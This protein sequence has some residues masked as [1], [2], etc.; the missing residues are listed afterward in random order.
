M[1][2]QYKINPMIIVH[3]GAWYWDD[4]VD[5]VKRTGLVH[6]VNAGYT[7]LRNGASALD[8]VESAVRVLEDDPVFDA[9]TG[10]YLNENGTVQLDALIVDGTG[11]DFGAVAGVTKTAHPITLAR[12]V[13]EKTEQC[14]FVGIGA[15]QLAQ[16]FDISIVQNDELHTK[17]MV[18]FHENKRDTHD[19]VGAVAI[20]AQGRMAVATSTSGSPTKPAGRVGDSPLFGS[21]GYAVN[22]IGAAGATGKG[23]NIMRL[24]MSRE[25]CDQMHDG[26][27]ATEAVKKVV[28]L[29]ENR[30]KNSMVGLIAID[31][32]GQPGVFHTTPKMA[33]GWVDSHGTVRAAMHSR[34]FHY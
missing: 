28:T 8:A 31:R 10:G 25:A 34:D 13:M 29:A 9:G 23:E 11:P 14:F 19:T 32:F 16:M 5:D 12:A 18:D 3:G 22:G 4:N 6:A 24:L 21:G 20:D 26:A 2:E 17:H 7:Q 27:S 33:F 30:F 15:D 1:N